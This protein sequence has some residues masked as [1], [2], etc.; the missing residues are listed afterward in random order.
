MMRL[1]HHGR[2]FRESQKEPPRLGGGRRSDHMDFSAPHL[3][4]SL[5][6]Q[7]DDGTVAV[8]S[9]ADLVDRTDDQLIK[10]LANVY[11]GTGIDTYEAITG[12]LQ[13]RC[14]SR[15]SEASARLRDSSQRLEKLTWTLI[16]LTVLLFFA[17][18]P[19]TI[20]TI[21]RVLR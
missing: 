5:Q 4:E 2:T 1:T 20:E 8:R 16:F 14:L 11:R 17:A 6:E 9:S 15:L 12:E 19:S 3:P 13:R 18:V 7:I 21:A 10:R